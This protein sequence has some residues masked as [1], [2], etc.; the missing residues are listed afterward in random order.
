MLV[1]LKEIMSTPVGSG[2]SGGGACM[3]LACCCALILLGEHHLLFVLMVW[4]SLVE[5]KA[6]S[7]DGD[8]VDPVGVEQHALLISSRA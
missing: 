3:K 6:C 1:V 5:Q 8:V 7:G 2:S 4:N